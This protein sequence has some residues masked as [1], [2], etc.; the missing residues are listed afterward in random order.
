M[1][2]DKMIKNE[3]SLEEESVK[4]PESVS[5]ITTE[6]LKEILSNEPSASK[7]V[8]MEIDK[9]FGPVS[10]LGKAARVKI[11]YVDGEG[12]PK[13]V[14]VKFQVSCSDKKREGEIYH[15]LSEAEVSFVPRLYGEF[16]NGNLVLEDFS[17][18]HSVVGKNEEFT[19]DQS[20]KIVSKLADINSRFY[21]DSRVPKND[22]SHFINSININFGESWEIFKNRYQAQLGKEAADFEWMWENREIVSRLYNSGPAA[23][24]HGGCE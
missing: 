2:I 11:D 8:V 24:S 14:I 9:E 22:L 18:T 17:S 20:R 4:T 16:G 3:Q 6:W 15:L 23:L 5:E 7:I 10:L 12:E 1:T 19:L 21:G 13:S